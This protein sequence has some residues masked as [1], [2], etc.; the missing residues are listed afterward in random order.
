MWKPYPASPLPRPGERR[1]ISG[2]ISFSQIIRPVGRQEVISPFRL[3]AFDPVEERYIPISTPPIPIELAQASPTTVPGSLLPDVNTP[4]EEMESILGLVDPLRGVNSKASSSLLHWW[5]LLPALIAILL[6]A[7]IV[8]VRLIP[9]WRRPPAAHELDRWITALE[10]TGSTTRN[11]LRSSGSFIE[12]W[13]PAEDRDEEL[14]AILERRDTDCFRPGAETEQLGETERKNIISLLS[15]R[16]LATLSLFLFLAIL[17]PG[18]TLRAAEADTTD[19]YGQ[20]QAAW[21]EGSYRTALHLY[22]SAHQNGEPPSADVLYNIGNCQFQLEEHGVAALFY[23]RAL[24]LDPHHAEARQNLR[25]LKRKTGAITIERPVY[26]EYLGKVSRGVFSTTL[27]ASLWLIGL[28]LLGLFA[29]LSRGFRPLI[30]TGLS[31][32]PILAITSG[33]G[34]ALYPDDLEFAPIAEQAVTVNQAATSARTEATT[35]GAEVISVPPG[36]LCRPLAQRGPWTYVE[37]ANGTRGWLPTELVRSVLPIDFP[38]KAAIE[39][40]A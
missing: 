36:S 7:Q 23:R 11:F 6:V 1:D 8:R 32:A 14:N 20:A 37:L 31:V 12:H 28:A 38:P 33:V 35:S 15:K 3:I 18:S 17:F 22:E 4:V 29:S 39:P 9:R 30:W 16:A 21:N 27:V 26:Q 2:S 24:H 13:I 25:F 19:Y 34:L 40:S 5:H 10:Q